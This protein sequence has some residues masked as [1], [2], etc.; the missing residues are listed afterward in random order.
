MGFPTRWSKSTR[1]RSS[2]TNG[3]LTSGWLPLYAQ[4][5]SWVSAGVQVDGKR[6]SRG[7]DQRPQ[8]S[9]IRQYRHHETCLD[10]EDTWL[11]SLFQRGGSSAPTSTAGIIVRRNVR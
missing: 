6:A 3:S 9:G 7:C 11:R 1:T 2:W 10:G 4:S 8:R 5:G